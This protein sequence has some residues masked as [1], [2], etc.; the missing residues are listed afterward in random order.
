MPSAAANILTGH[1][2]V[3]GSWA[4]PGKLLLVVFAS[5]CLYASGMIL[6]DL[7]DFQVDLQRNPKRP[8]PSEAITRKSA[9]IAYIALSLVGVSV[10]FAANL[11]SG[12]IATA[13]VLA[14]VLYD[15]TLK[16]TSVAP[17]LMGSCRFLNILLGGSV[18]GLAFPGLLYWYA[19]A[20]AV[21]ITG[22][23]YF[24]RNER[25][26]IS[27]PHLQASAYAISIGVAGLYV[28]AAVA[29]SPF[30]VSILFV[31]LVCAVAFRPTAGVFRA[32]ISGD[33][34]DVH[35]AV[36]QILKSLVLLDAC[37]CF[38]IAPSHIVYALCVG[39]LVVPAGLLGR[40]ISA[41]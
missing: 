23:T 36:I 30:V 18:S 28:L 19:L 20:I 32:C 4:P 39:A 12:L 41:T 40:R 11:N 17:I 6:N 8:L 37:V 26:L 16:R 21:L 29:V 5:C 24:A 13:L 10:C 3:A 7:C 35:R 9:T 25:E 34:D 1:L 38:L 22:L 15:S 2:I 33:P 14:I 27:K 31:V